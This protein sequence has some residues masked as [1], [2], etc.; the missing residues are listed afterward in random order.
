MNEKWKNAWE[1]K[2]DNLINKDWGGKSFYKTFNEYFNP[3]LIPPPTTSSTWATLNSVCRRNTVASK[4]GCMQIIQ[5]QSHSL[6]HPTFQ[7]ESRLDEQQPGMGSGLWQQGTEAGLFQF[8]LKCLKTMLCRCC[9]SSTNASE[10]IQ[11]GT[12]CNTSENQNL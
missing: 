2:N 12:K 6:D 4:G 8:T 5:F 7:F 10:T 9:R 3:G 1:M 11:N